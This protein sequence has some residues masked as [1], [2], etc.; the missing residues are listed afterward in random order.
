MTPSVTAPGDTNLGDAN[1]QQEC[2]LCLY[3]NV[4]VLFIIQVT[5]KELQFSGYLH[6]AAGGVRTGE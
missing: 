5:G 3:W 1:E 2:I 6:R 4:I